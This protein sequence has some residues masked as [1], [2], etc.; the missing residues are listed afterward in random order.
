MAM[1][2]ESQAFLQ[3]VELG[4]ALCVL[5]PGFEGQGQNRVALLFCGTLTERFKTSR[6]NPAIMID[7]GNGHVKG[8]VESMILRAG[9]NQVAVCGETAPEKEVP[10][11]DVVLL[12]EYVSGTS[13][14]FAIR[15]EAYSVREPFPYFAVIDR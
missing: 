4:G 12:G 2:V 5:A 9:L 14:P 10:S 15:E 6:G 13:D 8:I 7:L 3:G 1:D 11:K